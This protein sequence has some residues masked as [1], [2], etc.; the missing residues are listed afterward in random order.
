MP[1]RERGNP[2]TRLE[3]GT[4]HPPSQ[5]PGHLIA[6]RAPHS[7]CTHPQYRASLTARESSQNSAL[8]HPPH[9]TQTPTAQSSPHSTRVL[10]ALGTG[11]PQPLP[12]AHSTHLAAGIPCHWAPTR[13]LPRGTQGG[14]SSGGC[15]CLCCCC[16]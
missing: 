13:P 6:P 7:T 12:A 3:G 1:G 10:T 11:A 4:S 16:N 15:S 14:S 8:A 2:L 5:H 9:S